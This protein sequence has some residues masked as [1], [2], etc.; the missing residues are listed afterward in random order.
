MDNLLSN[1]GS[2]TEYRQQ[3]VALTTE[4]IAFTEES[5]EVG[6]NSNEKFLGLDFHDAIDQNGRWVD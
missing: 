3:L 1:G 5:S 2:S 4:H 6:K